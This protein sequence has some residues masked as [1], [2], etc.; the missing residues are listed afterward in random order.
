VIRFLRCRFEKDDEGLIQ[1]I[2]EAYGVPGFERILSQ[3]PQNELDL[4]LGDISLRLEGLPESLR[5]N[6]LQ[7]IRNNELD[8]PGRYILEDKLGSLEL[9]NKAID[10]AE[11]A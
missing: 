11:N 6:L 2:C 9:V 3:T 5:Q 4:L 10:L 1:A 8:E 7:A